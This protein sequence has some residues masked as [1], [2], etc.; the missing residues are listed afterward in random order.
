MKRAPTVEFLRNLG[1]YCDVALLEPIVL[2]K[3][4]RDRLV[5]F[6]VEKH[7]ILHHAGH[8]VSNTRLKSAQV[9]AAGRRKG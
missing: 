9:N 8:V 7:E 5:L 3:N 2:T 1:V 4:G 6:G